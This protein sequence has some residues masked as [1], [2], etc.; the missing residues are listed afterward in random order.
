M[1]TKCQGGDQP[2]K[3]ES[4]LFVRPVVPTWPLKKKANDHIG[5]WH[6]AESIE[7]TSVGSLN[8]ESSF[9]LTLQKDIRRHGDLEPGAKIPFRRITI[10]GVV[11]HA[12]WR[13]GRSQTKNDADPPTKNRQENT[14]I[15]RYS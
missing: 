10:R 8:Y 11:S 12:S 7:K 13:V 4:V 15:R 6:S 9:P 3:S 2:M 5:T 1:F 14:S